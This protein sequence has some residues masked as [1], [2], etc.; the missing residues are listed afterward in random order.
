MAEWRLYIGAR[1]TSVAVVPDGRCPSMWRV[2][3]GGRLSDMAILPCARDVALS[4]ARPRGL[5]SG[6][7]VHWVLGPSEERERTPVIEQPRSLATPAPTS[8]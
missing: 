3:R 7:V 8:K 5:G 6:E 1:Y 2:T 4:W